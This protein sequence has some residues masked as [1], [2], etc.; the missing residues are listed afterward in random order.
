MIMA[1]GNLWVSYM[2]LCLDLL[3]MRESYTVRVLGSNSMWLFAV[4]MADHCCPELSATD[5]IHVL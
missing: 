5:Y 1:V 4:D 2:V 3:E